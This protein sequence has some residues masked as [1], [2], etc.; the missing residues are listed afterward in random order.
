VLGAI[1]IAAA[2]ANYAFAID[3]LH[4][5]IGEYHVNIL[6]WVGL[7]Q[8]EE[9]KALLWPQHEQMLRA[10]VFVSAALELVR[11]SRQWLRWGCTS[12]KAPG[13]KP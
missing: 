13:F 9:P 10:S 12:L 4:D 2:V 8:W 7:R 3:W 11:S 1:A 5:E 6:A